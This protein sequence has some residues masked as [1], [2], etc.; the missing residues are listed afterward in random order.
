MIDYR[1]RTFITLYDLM[2][3]RKT[4]E[5][6]KLSQPAVT[7]QIHSLE[8][9]YGCRL[10]Y[11]DGHQLHRTAQADTLASYARVGL[12]ND[13]QMREAL[14]QPTVRT[15]RLGATKTIGEFVIGDDLCRFLQTPDQSLEV[16]VDNTETLLQLLEQDKLDFAI[17]EGDFDKSRYG[18]KL[19]AHAPFVGM[20]HS[21][22]P[23]AGRIVQYDELFDQSVILREHGSG[24]R[25]IFENALH[26]SGHTVDQFKRVICMSSF[27]LILK[28]LQQDL[29]ISFAYSAVCDGKDDIAVFH[30]DGLSEIKSFHF[31]YLKGAD[32]AGSIQA[33]FP[34]ISFYE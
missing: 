11:Y 5:L 8:N 27:S 29:G 7:Q 25:A 34:N 3:Y 33:I 32:V 10:F 26:T 22:H 14:K 15:I 4:A 2:H 23:F 16:T 24:T 19:F 28:L 21:R 12:F 18:Y 6:L 9:E 13:H 31:V 20:C 30:L 1:I 17:V